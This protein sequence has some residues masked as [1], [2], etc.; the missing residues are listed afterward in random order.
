MQFVTNYLLTTNNVTIPGSGALP[1][2]Q[3]E[4][5]EAEPRRK[6]LFYSISPYSAY[7]AMVRPLLEGPLAGLFLVAKGIE[8]ERRGGGGRGGGGGGR[9]DRGNWH[10]LY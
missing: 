2:P 1:L 4:K 5:Q 8:S 9:M 10:A 6:F 3:G 7:I